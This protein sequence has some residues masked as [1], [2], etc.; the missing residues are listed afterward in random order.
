MKRG[1]TLA[2]LM[3]AM[4]VLGILLALVVPIIANTRPDEFKMLTKK[5]YYVTE[6]VV[7]SLI[8]D[9]Q[10]YPDSTMYCEDD[11]T[12]DEC[13]YGFDDTSAV[14]YNG[15]TADDKYYYDKYKFPRLFTAQVN[16]S[17]CEN[18]GEDDVDEDCTC[19]KIT[20]SD[21]MT[22]DFTYSASG[23]SYSSDAGQPGDGPYITVWSQGS[24]TD[25]RTILV[26]V[27]GDEDPNCLETDSSCSHPDQ[28]RIEVKTNGKINIYEG[29]ATAVSNIM[30]DTA[31]IDN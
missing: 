20:T 29:D 28:F 27:N 31:V 7:S 1:F 25:K 15:K 26:D 17:S 22:F 11:D 10:L 6:Q 19:E 9:P 16:I 12:S 5:A 4:A 24:A 3:I 2:E 13:Y 30:F 14:A 23:N 21:G 8:N 18:G